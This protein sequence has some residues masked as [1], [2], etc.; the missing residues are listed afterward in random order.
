MLETRRYGL[1]RDSVPDEYRRQFQERVP[2]NWEELLYESGAVR[3]DCVGADRYI[4]YSA[5]HVSG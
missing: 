3:F 4:L 2:A 1:W 5:A